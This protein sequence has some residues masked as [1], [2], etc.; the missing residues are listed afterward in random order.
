[1]HRGKNIRAGKGEDG[2]TNPE[3][4]IEFKSF[5]K[6]GVYPVVKC[7]VKIHALFQARSV[8]GAEI[9]HTFP[10]RKSYCP[11]VTLLNSDVSF[12]V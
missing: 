5:R 1:M 11:A 9:Q 7:P 10:Q 6:S 4:A 3:A 2:E 8:S 12:K